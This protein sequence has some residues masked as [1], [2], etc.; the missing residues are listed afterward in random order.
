MDV[1]VIAI[2]ALRAARIMAR[3]ASDREHL[4]QVIRS[5]PG[6]F[7]R[8]SV[9]APDE[10]RMPELSVTVDEPDDYRLVREIIEQFGPEDPVFGCR[11]L[12]LLVEKRPELLEVNGAVVR[13]Y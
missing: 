10:L 9:T 6:R 12:I 2:E 1:Q 8:L 13:R 3:S 5:N 7:D 11:D 4:T